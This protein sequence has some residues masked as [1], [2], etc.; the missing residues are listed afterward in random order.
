MRN[1]NNIISLPRAKPLIKII[2]TTFVNYRDRRL[3]SDF[4]GLPITENPYKIREPESIT[5][6]I[7]QVWSSWKI[8]SEV[9]PEQKISENWSKLVGHKLACKCAPEKLELEKGILRIRT[10]GSTVKQELI[11]KKRSLIKKITDLDSTLR[12]KEIRV[13]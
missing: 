6:I 1:L 13:N 7:D 12:V 4:T 2:Y 3:I 11:F 8:G 5:D 10:A 9:T